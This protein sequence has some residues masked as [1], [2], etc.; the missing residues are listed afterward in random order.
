MS[1]ENV[2][3]VKALQP[4]G[5]DLVATVR[6]GPQA[7]ADVPESLFADDF[8]AAFVAHD[9]GAAIGPYR[10]AEG[11]VAGWLDWLEPWESYWI[12]ADEFVDAGDQ[13]IACVHI[14]GRTRRDGVEVEHAPAA[15]WTL[16]EG[17]VRRV[18]FYLERDEALRAVG[19]GQ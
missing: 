8:E 18:D 17:V 10:G 19:L 9:A 4:S 1:Q 15:V 6:A 2:E 13:V 11:F 7:F 3:I 5:V 14:R 16:R 12:Q